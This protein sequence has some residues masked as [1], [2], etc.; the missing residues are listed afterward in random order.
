M[1]NA[2]HAYIPVLTAVKAKHPQFC[3]CKGTYYR[4]ELCGKAIIILRN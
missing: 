1:T 3:R 4:R 2:L